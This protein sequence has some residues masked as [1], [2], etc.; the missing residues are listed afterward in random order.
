MFKIKKYHIVLLIFIF[1]SSLGLAQQSNTGNWFVYFGNQKINKKWSWWNE[2]QI[3]NYDFIGDVQQVLLRTGIGYDLD[4][5]S[6][7]VLMG[8]AHITN[9]SYQSND[10]K[11]KVTT[12]N[13]L[14]QQ[15]ILKNKL[16]RVFLTHRYRMEER[17]FQDDF[18]MRFRYFL[19]C[20]IPI[21]KPEMTGK[22][23]YASL[24]NE[25]FLQTKARFFDRN[26]AYAALGYVIN[27]SLKIEL[28][29]MAQNL[30]KT[31]RNQFQI[32]FF[33]NLPLA[34]D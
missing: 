10:S 4:E 15:F 34:K 12:E 28:G 2:V 17:F 18:S 33:N 26:R 27:P 23:W 19:S 7:N 13:R 22:T 8:Y 6:T 11:K 32:V 3:R 31:S 9:Y 29:Y 24:Y 21:N 25:V 16:N 1:Q 20:N 5:K 30:E 14:Y